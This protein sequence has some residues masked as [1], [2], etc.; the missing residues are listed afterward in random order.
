[1]T[2]WLKVIAYAFITLFLGVVL[3]ELG[4]KGTRLVVLLGTVSLL[5]VFTVYLADVIKILPFYGEN[6]DEYAVTMLKMVGV[7]YAFG[8]CSDICSEFGEVALSGVVS[9]IG[10]VEILTLSLPFIKRIVEK[11]VELI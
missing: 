4:F 10:R 9:L 2:G 8:I 5:G 11:G 7:G 6:A 1:M 3:R